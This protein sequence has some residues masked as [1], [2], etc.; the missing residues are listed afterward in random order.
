LI[1]LSGYGQEADKA[2]SRRAGFEQHLVKPVELD[3]L[4]RA[5]AE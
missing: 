3:D 4:L 5:I 2:R 1:A